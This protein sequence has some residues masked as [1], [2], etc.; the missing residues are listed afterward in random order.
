M[1][2]SKSE[3]LLARAV[4]LLTLGA[5]AWDNDCS[6]DRICTATSWTDLGGGDI[7][8]VF[9]G[10][11][12]A[13]NAC[14]WVFMAL[15]RDP[16]DVMDCEFYRGKENTLTLLRKIGCDGGNHSA[17]LSGV[18]P[19][20]RSGASWL[21]D[22]AA[23]INP[24]VAARSAGIESTEGGRTKEEEQERKKIAA[25]EK[26]IA[27]MKAQMAKFAANISSSPGF[28]DDD[29]MSDDGDGSRS[30]SRRINEATMFSTPVRNRSLPESEAVQ[31][32]DLS[33]GDFMF[34]SPITSPSTP[35]SPRTP[36][37]PYS[38]CDST[39]RT[40][41][42]EGIRLMTERPQCI[43]CGADDPMHIDDALRDQE[44]KRSVNASSEEDASQQKIL[45]FCGY[46]QA[47]TVIKD[48]DVVP[49]CGPCTKAAY[50]S[51]VGVHITLCGHAIHKGCCDAYLKTVVSQRDDRLEGGKRKEFRCPLCQRLS[52]CL[53]PFVDVAADWADIVTLSDEEALTPSTARKREEGDDI[54]NQSCRR[55]DNSLHDFLSKSTWWAT[56][57]DLSVSWDGHCTFSTKIDKNKLLDFPLLSAPRQPLKMMQAKF[58]KK[59]LIS[60]WNSILR[61]PRLV[62]RRARSFSVNASPTFGQESESRQSESNNSDV[63]RRFLDQ[64]SD[65]AYRAGEWVF[66]ISITSILSHGLL[67]LFR[68]HK[69]HKT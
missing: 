55:T 14:D 22:Y 38:S 2:G 59:E 26:A 56:K 7:G 24:I 47:S 64:V 43:V 65:V 13:P 58:G 44:D 31:A 39:P 27:A 51:H 60:A 46:S 69:T 40:S 16:S 18:D 28:E 63:L 62:K 20:L 36:H 49:S 15:L 34:T 45:A 37:T 29:R 50:H 19:A 23:K 52:N 53:V 9:H 32:I 1:Y 35:F 21:C 25:K 33:P 66:H 41:H 30:P 4:H 17:F 12:S 6:N 42:H 54:I 5:Y 3:T 67:T 8:S 61:T 10:K 48:D 11:E 68:F 57:N